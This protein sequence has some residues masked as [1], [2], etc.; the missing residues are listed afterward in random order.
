MLTSCVYL[1]H[2]N[3]EKNGC[4]RKMEWIVSKVFESPY[5]KRKVGIV[6]DIIHA[7]RLEN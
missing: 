2:E 3:D 6:R 4:R 5:S 7:N 1:E